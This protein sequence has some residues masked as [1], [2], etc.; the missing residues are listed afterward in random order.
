MTRPQTPAPTRDV[1]RAIDYLFNQWGGGGDE[2]GWWMRGLC[3]QADPDEWFPEKGG[4]TRHAKRICHRCPVRAECLDYAI[5]NS[6][7]FGVWG[8]LS[9]EEREHEA[10]RREQGDMA[11]AA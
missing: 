3:A 10:A 5:D 2:V 9:A 6:E 11:A 7:R 1:L 8:G 4:T